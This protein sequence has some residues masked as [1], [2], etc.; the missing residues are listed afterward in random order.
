MCSSFSAVEDFIIEFKVYEV[1]NGNEV[2]SIIDLRTAVYGKIEITSTRN[3]SQ[4]LDVHL[5]EVTADTDNTTG[6]HEFKLI[7]DG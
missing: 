5:R 6:G 1:D 3:L 4:Q 2:T 7:T